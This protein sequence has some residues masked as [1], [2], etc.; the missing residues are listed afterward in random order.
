MHT[1]DYQSLQVLPYYLVYRALV[2][3]KIDLLRFAQSVS[4]QQIQS[5]LCEYQ[6]YIDLALRFAQ[7][8]ET[9][10]FITHGLAGSGKSTIAAQLVET[11]GAIRIRSDVERK[12]LAGLTART[13]S[14][15][16]L[17]QGIYTAE[18]TE[19]TYQHVASCAE[20]V[21]KAGFSTIVDAAF[22]QRWQREIFQELAPMPRGEIRYSLGTG[23][24]PHIARSYRE[25]PTDFARP[26]RSGSHRIAIATQ[27]SAN[28]SLT[29]KNRQAVV[30]G[31]HK[32]D[33]DAL[34]KKN[35]VA[36]LL[37]WGSV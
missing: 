31:S 7:P 14:G 21:I 9:V 16:G 3:A 23:S 28:R 2:R 18:A 17:L 36:N 26:L 37:G 5:L 4:K 27:E 13:D 20:Q 30:I 22:L 19:K 6:S 8:A 25:T 12:R 32:N 1:G 35:T 29:T 24:Y 11:L 33:T 10:L 15:S 34:F